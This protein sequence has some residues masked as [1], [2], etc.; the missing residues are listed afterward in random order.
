M[1]MLSLADALPDEDPPVSVLLASIYTFGDSSTI[2]EPARSA[3]IASRWANKTVYLSCGGCDD[4]IAIHT[5]TGQGLNLYVR[6][7]F[8]T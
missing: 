6:S 2:D 4:C 3:P 1:V 5:L 7:R 8:C